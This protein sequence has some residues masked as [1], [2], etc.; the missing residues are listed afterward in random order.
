MS[1]LTLDTGTNHKEDKMDN[2]ELMTTSE[3]SAG[4]LTGMA[5]WQT[6]RDCETAAGRSIVA[7]VH[8]QG[9]ALLARTA[10][11]NAGSLSALEE[12]LI[13]MAPSGEARYRHIVD[14]YAIGAAQMIARW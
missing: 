9:R 2:N 6:K 12:Q 14:A 3:F 5:G 8:E 13:Q 4:Q 1:I 7:N 11:Q 10:L